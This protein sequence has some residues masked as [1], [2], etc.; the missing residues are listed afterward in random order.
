MLLLNLSVSPAGDLQTHE[1]NSQYQNGP[2]Q[3]RVL[4]PTTLHPEKTYPVLFILP[5]EKGTETHWGDPIKE[6][7]K[8]DLANQHQVIC[9]FPTF[10]ALPWY[11]DHPTNKTIRQESHLLHS[12]IPYVEKHYPIRKVAQGRFLLGFS[13]SGWG[14][15]SLLL[16]HPDQFQKA[17]AWDAPLLLDQPGPYGTKPIFGTTDNFKQYQLTRLLDKQ[18]QHFQGEPRLFH[19]GYDSFRKHHQQMD[20]K[21]QELKIK[22]VYRDGPQRQHHWE[23]GWLGEAVEL[24]LSHGTE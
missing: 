18:A 15:W 20:L 14:A 9:V 8:L 5:V 12:V 7:Q 10:S 24:L 22:A 13:K 3:V 16:R 19:W 11:A 21:L 17:M 2:T 23:S 4:T 1:L 6:V